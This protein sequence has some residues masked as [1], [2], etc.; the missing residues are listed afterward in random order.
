M[1]CLTLDNNFLL[2]NDLMNT[3]FFCRPIFINKVGLCYSYIHKSLTNQL[4][5]A[6][7]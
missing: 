2:M 4:L 3:L 7:Y 1:L 5:T 6:F